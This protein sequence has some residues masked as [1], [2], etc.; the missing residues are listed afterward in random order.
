M[1]TR[2]NILSA[3]LP[4]LAL[5]FTNPLRLLARTTTHKTT[6]K[7]LGIYPYQPGTYGTFET[8]TEADLLPNHQWCPPCGRYE[9]LLLENHIEVRGFEKSPR[10]WTL[11]VWEKPYSILITSKDEKWVAEHAVEIVQYL[12]EGNIPVLSYRY[13]KGYTTTQNHIGTVSCARKDWK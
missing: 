13:H 5:L 8:V 12:R 10:G 11:H 9:H 1:L 6:S 4:T 2:R 7:F 3:T